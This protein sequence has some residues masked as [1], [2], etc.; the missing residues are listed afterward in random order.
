M[1]FQSFF[2]KYLT[3]CFIVIQYGKI[4]IDYRS[5]L[6]ILFIVC[7]VAWHQ[8]W[9]FIMVLDRHLVGV[10]CWCLKRKV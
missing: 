9:Y 7:F 6:Y 5:E 10:Q 1:C 3:T 4:G 2:V 8:K